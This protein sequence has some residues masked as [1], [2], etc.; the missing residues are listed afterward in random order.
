MTEIEK[1]YLKLFL[2]YLDGEL[3]N[4]LFCKSY[5]TQ[6]EARYFTPLIGKPNHKCSV[7]YTMTMVRPM[8]AEF[9][10]Y[11]TQPLN[12]FVLYRIETQNGKDV[13][14]G[15]YR[16][17]VNN[18]IPLRPLMDKGFIVFKGNGAI[19]HAATRNLLRISLGLGQTGESVIPSDA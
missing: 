7:C 10:F 8:D 17:A 6:S 15:L 19:N 11:N 2:K 9:L 1:E 12:K 4:P 18:C 16:Q 5:F 3:R 14:V 13:H